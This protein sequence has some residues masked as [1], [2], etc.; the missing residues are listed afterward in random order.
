M[1][2]APELG[3]DLMA[4]PNEAAKDGHGH[5]SDDEHHQG[6]HPCHPASRVVVR[7]LH[8]GDLMRRSSAQLLTV[9]GRLLLSWVKGA[10]LG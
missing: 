8:L 3:L 1:N 9:M 5:Q 10:L 2:A 7:H 6:Q 4:E